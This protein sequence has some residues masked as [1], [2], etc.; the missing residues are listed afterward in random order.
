MEIRFKNNSDKFWDVKTTMNNLAI[1]TKFEFKHDNTNIFTIDGNGFAVLTGTL[2]QNSDIRLKK[3]IIQMTNNL[4]H[5]HKLRGVTYSWKNKNASRSLQYG[6]IAQELE[7][8]YPALVN[9]SN[10]YKSI[11]YSGLN[12]VLIGAVNEVNQKLLAQTQA[13]TE[14]DMLIQELEALLVK[15]EEK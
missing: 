1:N 3:N 14:N 2:T 7:K 9:T 4:A 11:N 10:K 15:L 8:V 12:A 6:L 5:I 13:L